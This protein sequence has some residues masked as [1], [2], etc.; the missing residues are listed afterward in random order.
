MFFKRF[1]SPVAGISAAV[2]GPLTDLIWHL[3]YP[4]GLDPLYPGLLVSAGVL[5]AVG[6]FTRRKPEIQAAVST[7]G[8]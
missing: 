5:F 7:G 3:V 8:E 4:K 6:M 1:V 2:L